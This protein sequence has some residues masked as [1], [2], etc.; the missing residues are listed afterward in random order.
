MCLPCGVRRQGLAA[1]T[2]ISVHIRRLTSYTFPFLRSQ[3][4]HF[5]LS[6][7]YSQKVKESQSFVIRGVADKDPLLKC[8]SQ[9]LLTINHNKHEE[10]VKIINCIIIPIIVIL[11]RCFVLYQRNDSRRKSHHISSANGMY[12]VFQNKR[13]H[14]CSRNFSA[15]QMT[16]IIFFYIFQ[17]PCLY[18]LLRNLLF[19]S[20][21]NQGRITG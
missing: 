16:R 12:R 10:K 19:Y 13:V 8:K 21:I 4:G 3:F 6:L 7:H 5:L 11:V 18:L 14:F 15:P 1:L 2:S 9:A 17:Q 20:W